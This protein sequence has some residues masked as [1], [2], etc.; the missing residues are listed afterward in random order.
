VLFASGPRNLPTTAT[1][2]V[3][4]TF[5]TDDLVLTP[6]QQYVL[7]V[8]ASNFFDGQAG[9]GV[10]GYTLNGNGYAGGS[11]VFA[12]NLDNFGNLTTNAW[13]TGDPGDL[14]F[15]ATLSPTPAPAGAVLFGLGLVSLGGARA[16]RRR[17]AA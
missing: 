8:S 4:F 13:V 9:S 12:E 17:P 6:G 5:D 16:L 1:Q 2:Y 11:F 3:T 10:V 7:F 15:T 14:A